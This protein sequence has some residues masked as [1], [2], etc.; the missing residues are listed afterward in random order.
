MTSS[1]VGS[2]MCIRDSSFPTAWSQLPFEDSIPTWIDFGE[3]WETV[4][5]MPTS[6]CGMD[7]INVTMLRCLPKEMMEA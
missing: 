5:T 6:S 2:E 7:G 3:I 4:Q 1:L